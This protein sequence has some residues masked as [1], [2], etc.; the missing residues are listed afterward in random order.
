M[1]RIST[2][3]AKVTLDSA[4][5]SVYLEA[6]LADGDVFNVLEEVPEEDRGHFAVLAVKVGVL[7][8]RDVRTVAKV[9]YVEKE[10]QRMSASFQ[11]QMDGTFGPEGRVTRK[12][13]EVFGETGA[14]DAKLR[15]F[16]GEGGRFEAVL[17]EYI[18]EGGKLCRS[19]DGR[20]GANGDFHRTLDEFLGEQGALRQALERE[21]GPNGGR[22]YRIL[23]P[24]DATTPLGQLRR[25]LEERFDPAREGTPIYELRKDLGRQIVQLR[26]DLGLK[27]AVAAER[28]KGHEKGLDFQDHIVALINQMAAPH[29][30]RV[31]DTSELRGPLGDVGDAV[32]SLNPEPTGGLERRIVVEA[33]NTKITLSG[34]ASIHK[35][36][37]EAMQNRDAHFAIAAVEPSFADAFAPLQYVAPDKVLV[38]VDAGETDNLP[39]EVAYQLARAFVV[40]RAA[41]REAPVNV[42]AVLGRLAEIT[43][44]LENVR[45]MKTNLTGAVTNIDNVKRMLDQMRESIEYTVADLV[46]AIQKEDG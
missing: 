2:T 7:A 30:D 16:F 35:E 37:D 15:G 42:E 14:I 46:R 19:L 34:R 38:A 29:G 32:V 26:Q 41:R 43:G 24:E 18:G 40:A 4:T 36:L 31:E 23:N 10:F 11:R 33:K 13:Q 8:L 27:E 25:T 9:D 45:A 3:S 21:F 5:R 17:E 12:I 1:G 20:I 44:H 22:L 39:L 6:V 28:A